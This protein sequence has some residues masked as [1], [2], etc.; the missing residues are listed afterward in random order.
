MQVFDRN[1]MKFISGDDVNCH[2]PLL[3][4]HVWDFLGE[5]TSVMKPEHKIN[6]SIGINETEQFRMDGFFL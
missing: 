4:K 3:T 5:Q 6:E 2:W 1:R